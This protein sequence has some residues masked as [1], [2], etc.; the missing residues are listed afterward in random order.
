VRHC[1]LALAVLV[2]ALAGCT[3]AMP[4]RSV[5]TPMTPEATPTPAAT[6]IETVVVEAESCLHIILIAVEAWIDW[7]AD[8]TRD[9]EDGPLQGVR[10]FRCQSEGRGRVT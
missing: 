6:Q 10:S 5:E 3:L 1:C 8:G 9:A 7:N 2:L 4:P